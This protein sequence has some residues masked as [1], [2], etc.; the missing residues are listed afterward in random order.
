M[1]LGAEGPYL[2]KNHKKSVL[3]FPENLGEETVSSVAELAFWLEPSPGRTLAGS[4]SSKDT[5]SLI[6][7]Q[8]H[9]PIRL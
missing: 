2:N 8:M 3:S 6:P 9:L 1:K 7:G 5:N 4:C